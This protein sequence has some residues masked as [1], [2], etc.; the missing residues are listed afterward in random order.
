MKKYIT[1]DK[2][3]QKNLSDILL[4][5]MNNGETTRRKIQSDTGF[6]W[7][8]ISNSVA[9]LIEKGYV[10]ESVCNGITK[11]AGRKTSVLIPRGDKIVGLGIDVNRAGIETVI[12]GFDGNIIFK[13]L[14][15]FN[16]NSQK[17]LINLIEN[18][19]D[20]LISICKDKYLI[21][22]I[23]LSFQ[24]E[25]DGE[26]GISYIFPTINDWQPVNVK[27]RLFNKYQIPIFF[28]HDPKCMLYSLKSTCNIDNALLIRADEGI[29]LAVM[30]EGKIMDDKKRLELGHTI[31]LSN[32]QV[33]KTKNLEYFASAQGIVNA[34]KKSI[35]DIKKDE[36]NYG[37]AIEN[38]TKY[39]SLA[40]YNL[41][42]LFRPEKIYLTGF[43]FSIKS[44]EQSFNKQLKK[45]LDEEIQIVTDLNLC[46]AYGVAIH[47]L[48][49]NIKANV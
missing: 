31:F 11:G 7:G 21:K 20:E 49:H 24:G 3:K 8:T 28:E 46:A 27:E 37:T 39:L 16:A 13:Q 42:V 12:I 43:L 47:S 1:L 6:S 40:V 35:N 4:Y 5:I 32:G 44:Y 18:I 19:I 33:D 2:L 26:N 9:Y 48:K 14:F 23:G 38:A 41:C 34:T 25:I 30:Q 10:Q 15:S 36:Q 29:G 22:S 45:L 17:E